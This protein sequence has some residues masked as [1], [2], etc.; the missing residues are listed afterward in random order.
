MKDNYD[1]ESY[2]NLISAE[3]TLQRN[4]KLKQVPLLNGRGIHQAT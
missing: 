3:V 2:D 1:S 4:D